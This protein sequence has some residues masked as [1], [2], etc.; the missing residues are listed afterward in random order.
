MRTSPTR[1][2]SLFDSFSAA[3][4]LSA[5]ADEHKQR[6]ARPDSIIDKLSGEN[7]PEIDIEQ[8]SI[9]DLLEAFD[10]V[11]RATGATFDISH[12]EDDTPIDFYQ[13]ELL[14]RLQSEGQL[15]FERLFECGS[16]RLVMVGLSVRSPMNRLNRRCGTRFLPLA[17]PK[18]TGVFLKPNSPRGRQ[19]QSPSCL[20]RSNRQ[21]HW[22]LRKSR[23]PFPSPSSHRRRTHPSGSTRSKCDRRNLRWKRAKTR[24]I[25][26]FARSERASNCHAE[27]LRSCLLKAEMRQSIG[28]RRTSL[29]R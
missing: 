12:I 28:G 16:G 13:I 8:L 25:S 4:L 2:R 6:F 20:V 19:F 3:N 5:A 9:W 23:L 10:S 27:H 1:V 18:A 7:E 24:R 11:C 14:H 21:S 29:R 17:S 26:V 22:A 15:T